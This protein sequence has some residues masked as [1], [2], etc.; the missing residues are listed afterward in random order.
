[1][2][3][4]FDK[5]WKLPTA[6]ALMTD[7]KW[8]K[9]RIFEQDLYIFEQRQRMRYKRNQKDIDRIK[10]LITSAEGVQEFFELL[11]EHLENYEKENRKGEQRL[12]D[13]H[14]N[15]VYRWLGRQV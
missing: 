1:M 11:L 8:V 12:H 3:V 2:T 6:L 4:D 15:P 14:K 7:I 10:E 9:R 13:F 5:V